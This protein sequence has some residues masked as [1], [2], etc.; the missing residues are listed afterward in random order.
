MYICIHWI[1]DGLDKNVVPSATGKGGLP[2][3]AAKEP[4]DATD[5]RMALP[6]GGWRVM[7]GVPRRRRCRLRFFGGSRN[8]WGPGPAN[9]GCSCGSESWKYGW[10]V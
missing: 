1:V 9:T 10:P 8:H 7:A 2:G 3:S 4:M 6:V 5:A